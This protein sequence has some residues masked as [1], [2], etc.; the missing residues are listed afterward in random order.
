MQAQTTVAHESDEKAKEATNTVKQ[1]SDEV[2]RLF[3]KIECDK[4]LQK[5]L[6]EG[7]LKVINVSITPQSFRL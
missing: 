5:E 7:H 4:Y 1:V 6:K 3:F 2:K